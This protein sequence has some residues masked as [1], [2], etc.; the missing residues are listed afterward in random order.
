MNV[1][2]FNYITAPL[3]EEDTPMDESLSTMDPTALTTVNRDMNLSPTELQVYLDNTIYVQNV[4]TRD[5]F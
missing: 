2:V 5:Q 3:L 4:V 1:N